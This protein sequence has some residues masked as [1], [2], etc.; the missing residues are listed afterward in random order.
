MHNRRCM[1]SWGAAAGLPATLEGGTASTLPSLLHSLLIL[2]PP[3][4]FLPNCP[5]HCNCLSVSFARLYTSPAAVAQHL[6]YPQ[7]CSIFP[8][9]LVTSATRPPHTNTFLDINSPPFSFILSHS[10]PLTFFTIDT[11]CTLT[12]YFLFFRLFSPF[13]CFISAILAISLTA[14]IFLS[15]LSLTKLC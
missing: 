15:M 9:P 5:L 14:Y 3:P 7:H 12:F 6:L 11:T 2:Y 10:P 13:P 1:C 8:Y 4:T